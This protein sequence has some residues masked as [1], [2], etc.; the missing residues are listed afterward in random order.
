[1]FARSGPCLGALGRARLKARCAVVAGGALACLGLMW[2][3][4]VRVAAARWSVQAMPGLV[5]SAA[6]YAVEGVSCPSITE[7]IAV[8]APTGATGTLFAERWNARAWSEQ[9]LPTPG[10]VVNDLLD[11][12]SC[13]STTACVAVGYRLNRR[14]ISNGVLVE[15]WNGRRWSI[16]RAPSPPGSELWSVSCPSRTNCFAVGDW[17]GETG[18]LLLPLVERWNGSSWSVE[19]TVEPYG[20]KYMV[21]LGGVSCTSLD[22]CTAVGSGWTRPGRE[23]LVVE[24]WDGHR[25]SVQKPAAPPPP[26]GPPARYL[27]EKAWLSGVSC[28]SSAACA[29]VGD[30]DDVTAE[31]GSDHQL[32]EFWNGKQWHLT[33]MQMPASNAA[34]SLW[35]VSCG[36]AKACLAIGSDVEHW[37]GSRWS[38]V[39]TPV[40]FPTPGSNGLRGVSCTSSTNCEV[41]GL[42]ADHTSGA[43]WTP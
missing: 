23:F 1:V 11:A 28:A 26:P 25:W 9:P 5:N 27:Q 16:D 8:G 3:V 7:C 37:N 36:S 42:I 29:A 43:R 19:R 15:A 4:G 35:G 2:V 14:Y 24:R 12:V 32:A 31:D 17:S 10:A 20:R 22:A 34:T 30:D 41:V 13:S 39:P 21:S 18:D 40:N 6:A 38:N 33:P